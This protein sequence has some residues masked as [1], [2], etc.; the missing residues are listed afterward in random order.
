MQHGVASYSNYGRKSVDMA[1]PG[2]EILS[3][4]PNNTY[5]KY[6]GTSMAAPMVSGLS[7]LIM[8]VNPTATFYDMKW[9]LRNCLTLKEYLK[10]KFTWAGYPNAQKLLLEAAGPT[11]FFPVKGWRQW[12]V[13]QT[14]LTAKSAAR[15]PFTFTATL[16][17]V[18][19]G[20]LVVRA[21]T[22]DHTVPVKVEGVEVSHLNLDLLPKD[23]VKL[24]AYENTPASV[25]ISLCQ[26]C[27]DGK[28]VRVSVSD[29]EISSHGYTSASKD[30]SGDFVLKGD[31]DCRDLTLFCT[32]DA[33]REK[34][35]HTKGS[36]TVSGPKGLQRKDEATTVGFICSGVTIAS[37]EKN[38]NEVIWQKDH[39]VDLMTFFQIT[40]VQAKSPGGAAHTEEH[41]AEEHAH[42]P[43]DS[44]TDAED[45]LEGAGDISD[46]DCRVPPEA[47]ERYDVKELDL[48]IFI[49]LQAIYS[50]QQKSN[51]PN[52]NFRIQQLSKLH[53]QDDKHVGVHIRTF[54]SIERFFDNRFDDVKAIYVSTNGI[55]SFTPW[56]TNNDFK[57]SINSPIRGQPTNVVA[58]YWADML[59]LD[60]D[61]KSQIYV[62]DSP[63][64]IVVQW[65]A[66][67]QY[68][69][70]GA[71]FTFQTHIQRN[72]DIFMA[73]RKIYPHDDD[74][75]KINVTL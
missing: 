38:D 75:S 30:L 18:Y 11:F 23:I 22:G 49:D 3:T 55:L 65:T 72:G 31:G 63:H 54:K 51:V 17:G 36:F 37:V 40:D 66:L 53:G 25:T 28:D 1:A 71:H 74:Q 57:P 16:P 29:I 2:T 24:R 27:E 42:E 67:S 35:R 60:T 39:K 12:R 20:D 33:N 9:L 48:D 8:S 73:Y 64:R 43:C 7:A 61:Q 58:P 14:T 59:S 56:K 34:H 62:L 69:K 45:T 50:A 41:T 5:S 44:T 21:S 26:R 47:F 15:I 68:G 70:P 46:E 19:S 13:H 10:A 52:T 6:S 32:L 4:T